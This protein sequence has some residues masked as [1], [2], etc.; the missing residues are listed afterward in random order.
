M[1]RTSSCDAFTT[2]ER[3]ASAAD[4][5]KRGSGGGVRL[6]VM[7]AGYVDMPLVVGS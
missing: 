2:D 7:L 5:R 3:P 1:T 6:H 4:A